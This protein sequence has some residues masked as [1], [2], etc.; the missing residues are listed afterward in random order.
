MA[1]IYIL[2]I[3]SVSDLL[4][5][6]KE[7]VSE[8]RQNAYEKAENREKALTPI[9]TEVLLAYA[10]KQN[11]P[12]AYKTDKKGKPY[13]PTLPFFNI[14]HSGKYVVCAVSNK[15][16]GVDIERVSRMRIDLSRRI[17]SEGELTKNTGVAGAGLQR[18]LCEKWVRKE[19]Y[20]KMTGDGL[21]RSMTSLCFDSDRLCDE[22][23][24]S[25]LFNIDGGYLLSFCRQEEVPISLI[26]IKRQ[27]IS[28]YFNRNESEAENV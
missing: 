28:D 1:E 17:L 24:F 15:E 8:R 20:L 22:K 18:L 16:V 2:D 21:R 11:L 4:I 27:D 5:E 14:S 13:I 12:L 6:L 23:V 9:A 3:T 7:R 19:A 10:L 26:E 25:R